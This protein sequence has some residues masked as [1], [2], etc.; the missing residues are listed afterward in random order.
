MPDR[1]TVPGAAALLRAATATLADAA[2]PSPRVDAEVLLAHVLGVDRGE[3]RRLALLDTPV[4]NTVPDGGAPD[5]GA[6]TERFARLVA[7]RV[8]REPLQHITG[9]AAFRH[10][11]LA[12]GPGVFVPRPETEEVAQVAIDAAA[13]AAA[14]RGSAVVVDLCTGS[15]AIA[16]SV[17]TGIIVKSGKA[18]YAW[19]T[20]LPLTWLAIVCTTAAFQKVFS[21]DPRL[22]FFA[23]ARNL[24]ERDRK[25]VV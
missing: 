20:G 10:L 21:S 5:D 6:V 9:S 22:G 25:S 8:R 15:G 24:A 18:K 3:V 2:V 12:V 13:H 14:D 7:R 17:A 23:G 4:A 1:V 11:E 19:V 16:L